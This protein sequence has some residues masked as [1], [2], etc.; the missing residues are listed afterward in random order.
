MSST[1][2]AQVLTQLL[3]DRNLPQDSVTWSME[4][5]MTG[6]AQ[7]SQIAAFLVALN[8]KGETADDIS[9][10][11][12]VSVSGVTVDTCGT[13]GDGAH[14][15]NIST[16]A[17]IV[18]AAAGTANVVKH[19]NRA[20]S[21]KCGSADVLEELGVRLD[22]PAPAVSE[23]AEKCG[24]TF[25]FA[26]AFHP[27]LRHVGPIR[28]ELGIPTVF[29]ILGPLANPARP[30]AQVVG[31]AKAAIGRTMAQVLLNRGTKALVVRGDEGLDELSI[32]GTSTI[33]SALGDE[34]VE[35]TFDPASLGIK[36]HDSA[37]LRG[38]DAAFNA[39]V[40]RDLFVERKNFAALT[41]AVCLNAAAALT[42]VDAVG[43][44]VEDVQAALAKNFEL[45][46]HV[47]SSG[48]AEEVL[49]HWI[50][51]SRTYA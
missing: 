42:A 22:L 44:P 20:A 4:E 45:A 12:E 51:T 33:W 31:V 38:G 29:N 27:A 9:A 35:F 11:V 24:I 17:A 5:M 6:Q 25:Y 15:V 37:A 46:K 49:E 26:Q 40:V 16:M 41:S 32:Q 14:T 47:I 13:G 28:R 7:P 18:V 36:T 34:V 43:A 10:L 19:G 8:A 3:V 50:S 23:V 30:K 1:T 48:G 2:W 21:S 39:Q